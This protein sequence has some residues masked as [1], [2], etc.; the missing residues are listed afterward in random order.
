MLYNMYLH[1][2]LFSL[3]PSAELLFSARPQSWMLAPF[4][5]PTFVLSQA[6]LTHFL[7]LNFNSFKVTGANHTFLRV[8][9]SPGSIAY[10]VSPF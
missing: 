8:S 2:F 7:L 1:H 4:I 10:L 5:F 3:P 6:D 9:D